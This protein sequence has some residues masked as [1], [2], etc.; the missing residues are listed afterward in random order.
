M[1]KD[2]QKKHLGRATEAPSK[3][4][5]CQFCPRTFKPQGLGPHQVKCGAK[6]QAQD[7]DRLVTAQYLE[8]AQ[9]A[10]TSTST[11]PAV[12]PPSQARF[13]G[14]GVVDPDRSM[15]GP[16][17]LLL[18]HAVQVDP[19]EPVAHP[20]PQEPTLAQR[21][22]DPNSAFKQGDVRTT[23]HPH[24]DK[25]PIVESPC[26][27]HTRTAPPPPPPADPE[28]W[29]LFGSKPA[30]DLA[31][32]VLQAAL[33]H[34]QADRLLN[35]VNTLIKD[36][37]KFDFKT[38]DDLR[39]AW[40][41]ASATLALT[42][43][44]SHTLKATYPYSDPPEEYQFDLLYRPLWGWL[45]DILSDPYLASQ[46]Q[47]D[48]ELNEVFEDGR[49]VR[50]VHEP[51]SGNR[52]WDIQEK[53]PADGKPLC[54]LLY[55]D[56]TKL[57]TFN[58]ESGY[59]VIAQLMNLPSHIRNGNGLGGGRIVG[60]L[61]IVK[62]NESEKKKKT[63]VDFKRVIW[64][65]SF[66]VI[67]R[68]IVEKSYNGA[69]FTCGDGI[70]RK[71]YPVVFVLSADYEEQCVMALI[72]G[73]NSK[74]PCPVC[75]VPGTELAD[76]TKK[77]PLRSERITQTLIDL[78]DDAETDKAAE[79][80]LK[81]AGLR[82][83]YNTFWVPNLSD[84]HRALSTDRMHEYAGGLGGRHL[85]P[86]IKDVLEELKHI[87]SEIFGTQNGSGLLDKQMA[88]M[89]RWEKL[90]HFNKVMKIEFTDAR[91]AEDL[92]KQLLFAAHNILTEEHTPAGYLLLKTL[93]SYINLDSYAAM[94]V[95]TE[96]TIA[97]G[98]EEVKRFSARYLEYAEYFGY[99]KKEDGTDSDVLNVNIHYPKAHMHAHLFDDIIDKGVALNYTTMVNERLHHNLKE[100]YHD[101]TNFR[102]VGVQILRADHHILAAACIR[103]HISM[104]AADE[105]KHKSNEEEDLPNVDEI[106]EELEA[107]GNSGTFHIGAPQPK[108]VLDDLMRNNANDPSFQGIDAYLE[109]YLNEE[110]EYLG[111][112]T[113]G[114]SIF[115]VSRYDSL[116]EHRYL[117]IFYKSLVTWRTDCDRLRCSPM[118]YGHPRFD[119]VLIDQGDDPPILGK[120]VFLFTYP[121]NTTD[122][123][124]ALVQLYEIYDIE[125]EA[126]VDLEMIRLHLPPD[127]PALL[128]PVTSFIRGACISPAFDAPNDYHLLD[129]VDTD[130]FLRTRKSY[131]A[132]Y[133]LNPM[134]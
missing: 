81:A 100:Y 126:E 61:P 109:K 131:P 97:A 117:K 103:Q 36:R 42:P 45:T 20:N 119:S 56:K 29:K 38:H 101:R 33:S 85:W 5:K 71:F 112:S 34:D 62:D 64:H 19:L 115:S 93:R 37:P 111:I 95:H 27:Y 8:Q 82:D 75:L 40:E 105:K 99:K 104:K 31:E 16:D 90:N 121:V 15:E 28:V 88:A 91:K 24:T 30:F 79:A 13:F 49:F 87:D 54:M 55:A 106:G 86:K 89:P 130:M 35:A 53:L 32:V 84:P 92:L 41:A 125:S 50:F 113:P 14:Y 74:R 52:F 4:I 80:I 128:F 25:T 46:C 22:E 132:Y 69:E 57:S 96:K 72:R 67:L 23:F 77:H 51:W 70:T 18:E 118:F 83:I 116:C 68:S 2:Y 6:M 98:R 76:H 39:A 12:Q 1:P 122:I 9:E 43:F 11:T 102:N 66:E 65:D 78:A 17:E 26:A 7:H 73:L 133:D 44:E 63:Y 134:A 110:Q 3:R 47:W 48:A 127:A 59:P 123:P 114:Q 94:R 120:L 58:S 129:V 124:L 60:W 107:L 10:S 21:L 108:I